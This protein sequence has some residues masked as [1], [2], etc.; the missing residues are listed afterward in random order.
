MYILDDGLVGLRYAKEEENDVRAP[1]ALKLSNFSATTDS[2]LFYALQIKDDRWQLNL[3]DGIREK[4]LELKRSRVPWTTVIGLLFLEA[5]SSSERLVQCSESDR[6]NRKADVEHIR[7][8]HRYMPPGKST[9]Q[10]KPNEVVSV[11]EKYFPPYKW[12]QRPVGLKQRDSGPCGIVIS[13]LSNTSKGGSC[14]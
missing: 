3:N 9:N 10:C 11:I 1:S 6:E 7:T 2:S 5:V 4:Q 8:Y 14:R 13:E 12:W